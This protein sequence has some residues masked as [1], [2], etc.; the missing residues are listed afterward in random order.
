MQEKTVQMNL[1][2]VLK[3]H[4]SPKYMTSRST[5]CFTRVSQKFFDINDN[6]T[7]NC[8]ISNKKSTVYICIC[9][10]FEARLK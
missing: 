6:Y 1:K 4:G 3:M 7:F 8:L 9:N 5:T 2:I 10:H